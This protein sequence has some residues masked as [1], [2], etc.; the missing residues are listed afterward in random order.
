MC[1]GWG[2]TWLVSCR[3]LEP[4][5]AAGVITGDELTQYLVD[6]A[7]E[8]FD[9]VGVSFDNKEKAW[10]DA[11]KTMDLPWHHLSDLKGWQCAAAGI[12]GINSIPATLLVG[13]DGKIIANGLRAH[14]L[15]EKLAEIFGE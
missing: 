7:E 5:G 6:H 8:G 15:A 10:K 12:Y 4:A 13:P 1:L 11:V 9:I 3:G 14:Q 2:S